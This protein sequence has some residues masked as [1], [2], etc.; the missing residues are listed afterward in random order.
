MST[1]DERR[2][3][4]AAG[5]RIERPE[6]DGFGT[7]VFL[8]PIAAPS[9][10]GLFGFAAATFVVA[11]N[12]AGW[13]GDHTTTPLVLAPFAAVFG[14]IAQFMAGMWAYRARDAVATAMHGA[15]GSFWI[16]YGV[17]AILLATHVLK[18]PTPW[19]HDPA[20]GFWFFA[21][22]V[23]TGSGA[24]AGLAENL[25]LFAVLATLATG[26]GLLAGGL[27]YGAEGVVTAAGWVLVASAICAW[28]VATAMM[29]AY[30]GGRVVLPLGKYSKAANTP[31]GRPTRA[32][33]LEW[34]EPGIRMGQ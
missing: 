24:L 30:A 20:F 6:L 22:A 13:Y 27:I 28:Y 14:G 8:Q 1:L 29:L 17:L 34:A 19:Y 23:V 25:G 18:A 7:R 12:L 5:T 33:E 32:I 9:I 2:E 11:A 21:L 15:W 10:L 4:A 26:S 16:A 3:R 31:G